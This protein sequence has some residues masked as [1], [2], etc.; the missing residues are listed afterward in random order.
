MVLK[1]LSMSYLEIMVMQKIL[2]IR[3][4]HLLVKKYLFSQDMNEFRNLAALNKERGRDHG[5]E[6][7]EY[8]KL[9]GIPLA[10]QVGSNPFTVFGNTIT[11]TKILDELKN[12]Y[13]TPENHIDLFAAGISESNDGEKVLGCTFGCILSKT[14]QAMGDGDRFYYEN[15]D[16]LSLA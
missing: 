8:K 10:K 12:I 6:S 13:G 16:A 5:L 2:I 1:Q 4:R 14:F 11:N 15:K 3:F 9:C 7:W